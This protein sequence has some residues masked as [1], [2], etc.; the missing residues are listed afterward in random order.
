V[1]HNEFV[2]L[3]PMRRVNFREK[4]PRW[5]HREADAPD[6]GS[7]SCTKRDS[8]RVFGKA[9]AGRVVRPPGHDE[10]KKAIPISA[11]VT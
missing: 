2:D 3:Q 10:L 9:K 5:V 1:M 6:H 8:W 7:L 11:P 4:M